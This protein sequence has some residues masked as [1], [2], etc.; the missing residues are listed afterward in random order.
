MHS[1]KRLHAMECVR[2]IIGQ[3]GMSG[4][5][6][7]WSANYARL[8]P[9]TLITVVTYE[10]LRT[11]L[12][13]DNLWRGMTE[14]IE[15]DEEVDKF[16]WIQKNGS[17]GYAD[18]QQLANRSE[19]VMVT[20]SV[21]GWFESRYMGFCIQN[22]GSLT[23]RCSWKRHINRETM[24]CEIHRI[25]YREFQRFDDGRRAVCGMACKFTVCRQASIAHGW[26]WRCVVV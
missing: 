4:L 25:S 12:G 2:R 19:G 1:K 16:G 10:N 18:S 6:R 22:D 11:A 15:W 14:R 17:V 21:Q 9:H 26:Q 23:R 8:G 20:I 3:E 24:Q 5:M 13:W 7:G